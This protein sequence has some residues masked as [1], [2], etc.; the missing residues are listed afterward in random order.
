[1]TP[2]AEHKCDLLTES[3]FDIVKFYDDNY[4]KFDFGVGEYG[5]LNILYCPF[6]GK[7]LEE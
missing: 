5:I 6:C 2:V 1:M 4:W 7:R 3:G